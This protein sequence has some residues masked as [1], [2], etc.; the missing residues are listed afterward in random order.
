[1]KTTPALTLDDLATDWLSRRMTGLAAMPGLN[2][3]IGS[4]QMEADPAA[5]KHM[6]FPPY[7]AGNETTWAT[8]LNGRHIAQQTSH[9]EIRWRA[10]QIERRCT[11]G[12]FHIESIT[13]LLPNQSGCVVKLTVT[14][15][16][17]EE[18][19]LRL[20]FLCSGRAANN[21]TDGYA[22]GVPSVP[23]DVFSFVKSEGLRQTVSD[24][25]IPDAIC[26]ANEKGNAHA[27]HAFNPAPSRWE[28]ERVPAW[29]TRLSPG[30]SFSVTLLGTFH[31]ERDSAV[32]LARQ[33][34]RRET[35]AMLASQ[36]LWEDLWSAAFTPDNGTFSG[37]LPTLHSPSDAMQRLYYNGVLTLLTCRR[38]YPGAAVQPAYLTLWPRRGEG[39][40]YLAWELNCTSGILA[41][42]DPAAL[43]KLWTLLASAPWLDYQVTNYFTAEHGGWVC[44]AHPQSLITGALHLQS[45][46]GDTAWQAE[47][48]VRKP[49]RT[50][51]F[52][53]ASQGQV[54]DET[55]GTSVELSGRDAFAQ[56]V[57]AHREH[58]LP[59]KALIDYGGRAAY[60]E[61]IS[62]YAHGTAGHTA[63]QAWALR[64]AAPVLG[65]A[66]VGEIE[67]LL[68]GITSLF[69]ADRGF[70]D[71]EYPDGTRHS[72]PNLYDLALVLRHA[73]TDLPLPMR[74]AITAFIRNELITPTWSHCLWPA[75]PD[76]LSTTRCDHQW[77]GCFG[78][79]IPMTV[80]GLIPLGT[81]GPWLTEWL[82]GVA[83]VTRQGPF[84]QAYWAEDVYP[85]EAGAAAKCFDELTQGNHWVICSGTLFAEM[86]IDGICGLHAT[87]DGTLSVRPGLEPWASECTLT[88]IRFRDQN[89]DLREGRLVPQG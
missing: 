28:S 77:S 2:N 26:M 11:A 3:D 36:K 82:E 23:T 56:A 4:V 30:A 15:K 46:S 21:G 53:A 37:H 45:W 40:S 14:N 13:S 50:A 87:P 74:E 5:I 73:G 58:H 81:G 67:S 63:I 31:E 78:A 29:E 7:S 25:E 20:A 16:A 62:T 85:P 47:T 22:W 38:V 52:E 27:V 69:H 32:A 18:K 80:L 86:V 71:C 10:Y 51:G 12:D 44:S 83:K 54:V 9:V 59:D 8:V 34:Q 17:A 79:W 88:N 42:L 35:E 6:I 60:L 49:R 43:H 76:S 68:A 64:E 70:F 19:A 55:E 89:Y 39:S 1:M 48:I 61:C 75:D 65:T 41:R 24:P 72:A 66:A 57:H 84:A 33:W